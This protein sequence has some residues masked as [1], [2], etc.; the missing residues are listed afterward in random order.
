VPHMSR[1][2][3]KDGSG[4]L[5]GGSLA[6]FW[7]KEAGVVLLGRLPDKWN[8]VTWDKI[9]TWP[10]HHLWGRAA[11][12]ESAFSS[13]RQWHPWTRFEIDR[14]EPKVHV[15]GSL[16]PRQTVEVEDSIEAG[17]IYYRREFTMRDE[18]LHIS[19]ELLSRGTDEVTELWETLPIYIA[20]GQRKDAVETSVEFRI[21]EGEWSAEEPQ[22]TDF[23]EGV[24]LQRFDGAVE[25]LFDQ[26]QHIHIGDEFTTKYQAKDRFRI[27][28]IDLLRSEGESI[29]MPIKSGVSYLIRSR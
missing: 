19:S 16:G 10:T 24:R 11:N 5:A 23:V 28:K 22:L 7:T 17:H 12:N 27:L 2:Y 15:F 4:A 3:D 20:D 21:V 25:I 26:P 18:G 9:E 6:A 8:Y 13:A 1:S 29:A 14:D